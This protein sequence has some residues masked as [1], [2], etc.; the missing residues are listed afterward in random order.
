MILPG[1]PSR[2]CFRSPEGLPIG[3]RPCVPSVVKS[4]SM[5]SIK[6]NVCRTIF[7]RAGLLSLTLTSKTSPSANIC[8]TSK[9]S[10]SG[11]GSGTVSLPQIVRAGTS[12]SQHSA[13]LHS[14][15]FF[16][17]AIGAANT[18]VNERKDLK[19]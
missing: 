2:R 4:I 13:F 9:I 15:S 12:I 16:P 5:F 6:S 7:R 11:I 17:I 8:A 3:Q 1:I 14:A 19:K 18:K 10:I